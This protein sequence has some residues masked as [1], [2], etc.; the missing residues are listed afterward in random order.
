[1]AITCP[2]CGHDKFFLPNCPAL[3]KPK[4]GET[5]YSCLKCNKTF[6]ASIDNV[7]ISRSKVLGEDDEEDDD[8]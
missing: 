7:V 6:N 5:T 1:M 4:A 3:W 8:D 2:A